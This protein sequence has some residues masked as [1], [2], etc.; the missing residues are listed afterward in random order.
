[1]T[2][3]QIRKSTGPKSSVCIRV[4]T[5]HLARMRRQALELTIA[6]RVN[7]TYADIIRALIDR[8]YIKPELQGARNE[9]HE[10]R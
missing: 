3:L 4:S 5:A 10:L 1:M 6:H 8:E 9:L 7:V 2:K